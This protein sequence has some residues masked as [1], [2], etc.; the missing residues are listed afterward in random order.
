M[1]LRDDNRAGVAAWGPTME[2]GAR[3]SYDLVDRAVAPYIGVHYE[4]VFGDT[5]DI[6]EEEGE[7]GDGLFFVAG[8]RLMF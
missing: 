3:L 8:L 4:R 1:P 7:E 5:L 2:I 6:R